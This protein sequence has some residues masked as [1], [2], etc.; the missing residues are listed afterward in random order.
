[1]I[2]TLFIYLFICYSTP[3]LLSYII[4]IELRKS[5]EKV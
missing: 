3:Y 5:D 4:S 1:M 2:N